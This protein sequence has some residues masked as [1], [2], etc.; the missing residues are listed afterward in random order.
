MA[1]H[2]QKRGPCEALDDDGTKG[3]RTSPVAPHTTAVNDE[4]D[5]EG[6]EDERESGDE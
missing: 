3:G 2:S 1:P 5:D 6:V 4:D